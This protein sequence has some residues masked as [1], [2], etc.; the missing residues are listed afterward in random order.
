MHIKL[1]FY[2][3]SQIIVVRFAAPNKWIFDCCLVIN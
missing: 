2:I 3:D 1:T